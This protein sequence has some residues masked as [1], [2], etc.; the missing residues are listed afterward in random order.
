MYINKRSFY[1]VWS[2]HWASN[3]IPYDWKANIAPVFKD[4]LFHATVVTWAMFAFQSLNTVLKI[5]MLSSLLEIV[6]MVS[7]ISCTIMHLP[8]NH[9]PCDF[10]GVYRSRS[11]L[12]SMSGRRKWY[13]ENLSMGYRVKWSRGWNQGL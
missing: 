2:W 13:M 5:K 8:Q 1:K 11:C 4:W 3:I 9:S 12:W 6:Q 7:F 10:F